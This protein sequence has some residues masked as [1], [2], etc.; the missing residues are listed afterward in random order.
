MS[1]LSD[2]ERTSSI[3]QEMMKSIY[4]FLN[5]TMETAADFPDSRLPTLDFSLWVDENGLIMY[6][7]YEKPMSCNQVMH[8]DSA[9]PENMR[10]ASLQAEV[11]RRMQNVSEL[12][13]DRERVAVLDRYAQKMANSGYQLTYIRK[14]LV[15]GLPSYERRLARSNLEKTHKSW[16]ALHESAGPNWGTRWRKKLTGKSTWYKGGNREEDEAYESDKEKGNEEEIV[17][18][19][20]KEEKWRRQRRLNKERRKREKEERQTDVQKRKNKETT[21]VMFLEHTPHG[22]LTRRLQECEDRRG[23]V[24]GRRVKMVEHMQPGDWKQLREKR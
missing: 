9:L 6:T 11:T 3:I 22:E 20:T 4:K 16:K 5:F 18:E 8:A 21:S 23:E 17:M 15:G 12:L 1:G 14:R 10:V 19:L 7:F 24:S 2:L 13:P